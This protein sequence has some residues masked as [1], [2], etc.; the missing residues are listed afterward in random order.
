VIDVHSAENYIHVTFDRAM[1]ASGDGAVTALSSYQL[2]QRPLRAGSTV[3]CGS[4][5][6]DL[7]RIDLPENLTPESSHT[8]RIASVVDRNGAAID[9]D[10]TIWVFRSDK[11]L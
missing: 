11:A 8:L 1:R 9:P 3:I 7:I 4:P 2:D 10:P 6:C 5:S